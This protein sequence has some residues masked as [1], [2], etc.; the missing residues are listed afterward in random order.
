MYTFDGRVRYSECDEHGDITLLAMINYL[1][2]C[3]TFHSESIGRGIEYM[4][5]RGIAWL[6]AAW[7]IE[8]RR[9]PRFCDEIRVGTWCHTMSNTLASRNFVICDPAGEQMVRADSLWFVY[10]FAAGRPIRVPEDQLV[11]LTEEPRLDMPRTTRKLP[12]RGE[13][14]ATPKIVVGE[15]HL[16]TNRHVNNAQYLG[17]ATSALSSAHGGEAALHTPDISRICVQYRQQ[18]RLGDTIVPVVHA[19]DGAHTIDLTDG[20]GGS[21]AVVR[22][23]LR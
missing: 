22:L 9:L 21:F 7:Q 8:V 5:E 4:H 17:M 14:I 20:C 15:Q 11:Y 2:D 18:A 13:G 19:D 16:D 10:D 1:Q 12:V 3:T 6:I 23:E